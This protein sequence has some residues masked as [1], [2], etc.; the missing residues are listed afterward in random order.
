LG[1][2][3]GNI[4]VAQAD[5][6]DEEAAENMMGVYSCGREGGFGRAGDVTRC[7]EDEG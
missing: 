2:P 7:V 1:V 3:E 4:D 5:E 6:P